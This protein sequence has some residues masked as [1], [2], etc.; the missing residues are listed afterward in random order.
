LSSN[1]NP[2]DAQAPSRFT[3]NFV[4]LLGMHALSQNV[5]AQLIGVSAATMSSWMNGKSTPSLGKA[6]AISELFGLPTDRLMGASFADLLEGELASRH[7]FEGVEERIR[8]A[9]TS[10]KLA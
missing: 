9:L 5:A 3:D 4:R 6:I 2:V 10:L 7:R 1:L 8:R